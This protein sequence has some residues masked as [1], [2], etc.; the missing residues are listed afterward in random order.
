MRLKLFVLLL[1]SA[2][3]PILA[4][5]VK[6]QGVVVDAATGAPIPGAT[7]SLRT[8]GIASPSGVA[9]DFL[10]PGVN[11]GQDYLLIV[12]DGYLSL[13]HISEPTRL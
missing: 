11:A 7:I 3:L 10:L 8:Q 13:I 1:L 6:L 5:T 9:G 12:A 4:R 2:S